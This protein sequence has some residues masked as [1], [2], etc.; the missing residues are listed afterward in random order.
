[1]LAT[2]L[3]ITDLN[4]SPQ[5]HGVRPAMTSQSV[6]IENATSNAF[7]A[8]RIASSLRPIDAEWMYRVNP[9]SSSPVPASP[10]CCHSYPKFSGTIV[11]PSASA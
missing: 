8:A 9:A 2:P 5:L 3:P 1:M 7:P 6:S 11:S 4:A 10:S